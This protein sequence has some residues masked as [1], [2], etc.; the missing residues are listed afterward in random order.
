MTL[1]TVAEIRAMS[2]L[3]EADGEWETAC[4][5]RR[6]LPRVDMT[7][8]LASRPAWWGE[9]TGAEVEAFNLSSAYE[10]DG[11]GIPGLEDR[12][13]RRQLATAEQR[14]KTARTRWL[15]GYA[16]QLVAESRA[17]RGVA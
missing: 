10:P 4:Q 17:R 2:L 14:L 9:A 1:P 7:D 13:L 5:L 16:A 8:V 11:S 6:F 12:E 3:M 15:E